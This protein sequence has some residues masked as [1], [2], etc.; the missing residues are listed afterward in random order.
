MRLS[1]AQAGALL[2][3]SHVTCFTIQGMAATAIG[4]RHASLSPLI[5]FA[6]TLQFWCEAGTSSVL[7]LPTMPTHCLLFSLV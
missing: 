1:P 2:H 3:C 4:L 5:I 7:F 6:T